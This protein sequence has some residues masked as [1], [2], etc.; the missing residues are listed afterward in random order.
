MSAQDVFDVTAGVFSFVVLW[1]AVVVRRRLLALDMRITTAGG[2]QV[3]PVCRVCGSYLQAASGPYNGQTHYC[4]RCRV[5]VAVQG[6]QD[7]REG[8]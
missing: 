6:P 5:W 8:L 4:G 1:F 2:F 7:T 3:S